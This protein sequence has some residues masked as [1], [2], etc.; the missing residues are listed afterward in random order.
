MKIEDH[1]CKLVAENPNHT[2]L[3]KEISIYFW[4]KHTEKVKSYVNKKRI[5]DYGPY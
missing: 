5:K 1:I 2:E 4:E 3:G